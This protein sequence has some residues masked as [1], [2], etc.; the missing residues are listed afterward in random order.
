MKL[1]KSVAIAAA[2]ALSLGSFSTTAVACEDGRTCYGPEQAIDITVGLVA[3]AIKAADDKSGKQE[4][5]NLIKQAKSASKEINANDVV[6]RKRQRAVG[7][8]KK[9]KK[10]LKNDDFQTAEDHLGKAEKGF[11]ALKN[12]L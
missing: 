4:V 6:D 10:A 2:L 12:F 1:L 7:E 8:L 5:M 11:A 3:E 9:A